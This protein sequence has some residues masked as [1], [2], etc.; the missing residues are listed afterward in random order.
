MRK[1]VERASGSVAKK[2]YQS[3]QPRGDWDTATSFC[4][5]HGLSLVQRCLSLAL[6]HPPPH[7]VLASPGGF[8]EWMSEVR[9]IRGCFYF[10]EVETETPGGK[11]GWLWEPQEFPPPSSDYQI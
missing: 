1:G 3:F 2:G 11:E 4:R 8:R 5:R 10:L 7:H 9:L 6:S